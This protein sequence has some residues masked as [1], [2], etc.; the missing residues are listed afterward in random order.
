MKLL[1]N[2]RFSD[3]FTESK[4]ELIRVNSFNI[5]TEIRRRSL[6]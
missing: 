5:R 6:R 1:E 2:L 3:D 4:S